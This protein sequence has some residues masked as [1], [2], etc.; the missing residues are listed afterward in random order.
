MVEPLI[1]GLIAIA[2]I[3]LV[4]TLLKK[5]FKLALYVM[6]FI[7]LALAIRFFLLNG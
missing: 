1:I 2:V 3:V 5:L 7:A 4:W 6:A